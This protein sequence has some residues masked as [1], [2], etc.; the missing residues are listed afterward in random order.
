MTDKFL[1]Y[2]PVFILG[3]VLGAVN[4]TGLWW[5]VRTL[6]ASRHPA[7]LSL[8]SFFVRMILVLSG[9]YLVL[10]SRWERLIFCLAGFFLM[11]YALV[12]RLGPEGKARNSVRKEV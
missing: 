3:A 11:R 8:G 12:R 6:P 1:Y 9:F 7:L 10:G 5:T 2:I 4:Y